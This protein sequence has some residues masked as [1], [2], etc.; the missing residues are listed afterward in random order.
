MLPALIPWMQQRAPGLDQAAV[1]P[2]EEMARLKAIGL[3]RPQPSDRLRDILV[4]I[5]QGN[6]SVGRVYEAHVNTLHLMARY[7]TDAQ[8]RWADAGEDVFALWVTDPPEGGLTM[9]RRG[10]TIRLT[11]SKQFC[12]GAGYAT[13]SLITALDPGIGIRMMVVRLGM[14]EKVSPL[15]SP[16]AGMR[17]AVTGAVDFSG[18]EVPADC[19][20][21]EPGDYLREPD[22]STGAWRGSAVAFGGLLALL[23]E[24]MRQLR[25]TGRLDSPHNQARMGEALIRRETSRHWVEAVARSGEDCGADPDH[26]VATVGLGR[27]AVELACMEAMNLVQ[28]AVGLSAF[29]HGSPIELICR[30][31]ATYLRQPAPDKTLVEA[32]QWFVAHPE[33][34]A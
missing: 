5:G 18:C 17:A 9:E 1:Y 32:A 21:G 29:R 22:F 4:A 11:G 6:L 3:L 19:I 13:A 8:R 25:A 16:L 23:D 20:L 15:P 33:A 28:R 14:G 7:G 10:H 34:T 24:A 30:D 2:A 27:V 31:L 26:R 12:S